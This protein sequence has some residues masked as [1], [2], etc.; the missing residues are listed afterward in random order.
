MSTVGYVVSDLYDATA[1]I[2]SKRRRRL[3]AAQ[4][5]EIL[6]SF[7]AAASL[8]GNRDFHEAEGSPD[9]QLEAN[10]ER[11]TIRERATG[12]TQNVSIAKAAIKSNQDN[13]VGTG[14][15]PQLKVNHD[16]LG[17][18]K[19]QAREYSRVAERIFRRWCKNS[20]SGERMPFW[21]QL[22]LAMGQMVEV[23][24]V[25]SLPTMVEVSR[26]DREI[27][28]RCEIVAAHRVETPID[29]FDTETL[30]AGVELGDRSQPIAYWVRKNYPNDY[31]YTGTEDYTR[32]PARDRDGRR[33]VIHLYEQIW[34][35]QTRGISELHAVLRTI[36]RYGQYMKAEE[37]AQHISACIGLLLQTP[38][39][40]PGALGKK[41]D[42]LGKKLFN[43]SP[44]MV[45]TLP[46]G[47]D[48]KPFVPDRKTG[49][50]VPPY[51]EI[52]ERHIA[53]GLNM[54]YGTLTRNYAKSNF[55]NTKAEIGH[56]N[57]AFDIKRQ[58]LAQDLPQEYLELVLEE[59]FLK[60]WLP[61][62]VTDFQENLSDWC[63]ADWIGTPGRRWLEPMK[64]AQA[65]Q[66]ALEMGADS[67][68]RIAK[69]RG[70]DLE[71]M[72]LEQL[73]AKELREELGL[74]LAS[75][76]EDPGAE[77]DG[78]DDDDDDEEEDDDD[79]E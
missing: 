60:G 32:I 50:N 64:D 76:D 19:K 28:R 33:K 49:D 2:F 39:A 66:I 53:N 30:R 10:G 48:V 34:P 13:V 29:K 14:I 59:A 71:E 56:D 7:E 51:L 57:L 44:G 1:S 43:M 17:I 63:R 52:L 21:R 24:E 70:S 79:D 45:K 18:T 27:E 67:E 73:E 5:E 65:A 77:P 22:R 61:D 31:Q 55:S 23:G 8:R 62:F 47:Y 46:H 35:G 36:N 15:V 42:A 12:A 72:L 75:K 6:A 68:Q 25:F 37:A 58:C 74:T 38:H 54:S 9:E 41:V 69:E 78:D 26:P 4:Q 40:T 11:V 16:E 3:R 20:D